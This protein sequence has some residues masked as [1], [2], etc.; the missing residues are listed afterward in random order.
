MAKQPT[1]LRPK[2]AGAC[3]DRDLDCQMA[4]EDVFRTVTDYAE[5]F[6]WA[7]REVAAA[8]IELAHNHW[9]ALDAKDRMFDDAAG[10]AVRKAKPSPVH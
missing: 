8:L 10:V 6:G 3:P 1:F 7:E 4:L 9:A 5:A 2:R